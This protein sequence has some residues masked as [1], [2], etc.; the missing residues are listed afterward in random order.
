MDENI[1]FNG[2]LWNSFSLLELQEWATKQIN[3]GK[4]RFTI[5]IEQ[6]RDFSPDSI[7]FEI[8]D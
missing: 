5:E 7:K 6:D 1:K 2:P 3:K 8:E 4:Q